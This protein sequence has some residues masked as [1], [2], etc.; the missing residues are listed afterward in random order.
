MICKFCG[1]EI[2]DSAEFCFICGQKVSEEATVYVA[3]DNDVYSHSEAVPAEPSNEF[4]AEPQEVTG[5]PYV[6]LAEPE[7][8]NER[9]EFAEAVQELKALKE[10]IKGIGFERFI[11]FMF[12][13]IGLILYASE[14]SKGNIEKANALLNALMTGLC[15][16]MG[17]VIL[18]MGK[19]YFL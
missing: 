15:V 19:K 13:I 4:S 14:K 6:A 18:I 17:I 7:S 9:D 11:C 5:E 3:G 2:D 12:A 10:K 16:K 1:N 8:E